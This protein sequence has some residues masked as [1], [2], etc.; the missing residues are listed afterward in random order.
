MK[1]SMSLYWHAYMYRGN[2]LERLARRLKNTLRS[3]SSM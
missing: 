2:E 3:V 1:E